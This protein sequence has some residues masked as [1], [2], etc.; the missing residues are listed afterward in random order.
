M[1]LLLPPFEQNSGLL[2]SVNHSEIVTQSKN[3]LQQIEN[4]L[5]INAVII[6]GF[7]LYACG[8]FCRN[9]YWIIEHITKNCSCSNFEYQRL[10]LIFIWRYFT[11]SY[12]KLGVRFKIS[13]WTFG[14]SCKSSYW[15][16]GVS[17]KISYWTDAV[18]FKISYWTFGVSSWDIIIEKIF[19]T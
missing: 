16:L 3:V 2:R 12:W 4:I 15:T 13:Y 10:S 5:Q 11:D 17:F 8:L 19:E 18:C 14:V 9:L 7:V 6:D 1:H